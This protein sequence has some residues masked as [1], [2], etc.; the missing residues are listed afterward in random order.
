MLSVSIE[1]DTLL[2]EMD[3]NTDHV[4][5]HA[6][7]EWAS[8]LFDPIFPEAAIETEESLITASEEDY[9]SS[10]TSAYGSTDHFEDV[11]SNES[12]SASPM[13][14]AWVPLDVQPMS[15][16]SALMSDSSDCNDEAEEEEEE[17]E[18]EETRKEIEPSKRKRGRDSMG[19]SKTSSGK[20]SRPCTCASRP[21]TFDC[22]PT[23]LPALV[24]N[25]IADSTVP[26]F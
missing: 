3:G 23:S 2:N 1:L 17:E 20:L 9:E 12:C 24:H 8:G 22:P 6:T 26:S 15:T 11:L 4:P 7:D 13:Q 18:E 16:G 21:F 14:S 5:I 25:S 19:I 10:G